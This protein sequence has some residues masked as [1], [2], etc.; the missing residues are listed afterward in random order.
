MSWFRKKAP[1]SRHDACRDRL[2]ADAPLAAVAE[3]VPEAP[4][5][6]WAR[7]HAAMAS[8]QVG[9]LLQAK[10]H[11]R[12]L[13]DLPELEKRGQLQAW[14]CLRELGEQPPPGLA[15]RLQGVVVEVA[16]G[17]GLQLL[18]AYADRSAH[19]SEPGSA[20]I[21][22]DEPDAAIDDG[23]V[24]LLAPAQRLA[25]K[26]SAGARQGAPAPDHS[27]IAVLTFAGVHAVTG[28]TAVLEQDPLCAPLLT[29]A[30][31]LRLGLLG[32]HQHSGNA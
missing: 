20:T 26:L 13:L 28:R 2:Y 19:L 21:E 4:D 7:F 29:A 23:I 25:D 31:A 6:P 32:K 16:T 1:A 15:R 14:S 10:A 8:R 11:L 9:D 22:W 17:D 5:T 18:A 3:L 12:S 30:R 24:T 27:A